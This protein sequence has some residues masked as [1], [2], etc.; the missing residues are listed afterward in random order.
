M[1][2]VDF[3][4]GFSLGLAASAVGLVILVSIIG[5]GAGEEGA[6]E[7]G[8]AEVGAAGVGA[9]EVGAEQLECSAVPNNEARIRQ[10][11]QDNSFRSPSSRGRSESPGS[12][13]GSHRAA[14]TRVWKVTFKHEFCHRV[15]I[16]P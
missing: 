1:R 4:G 10:E 7:V 11:L 9:A 14:I 3:L 13:N 15:E 8:A 6:V 2:A 12:S 5:G 16:I